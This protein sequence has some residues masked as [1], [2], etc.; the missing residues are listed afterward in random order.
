[1]PNR[2]LKMLLQLPSVFLLASASFSVAFPVYE[3]ESYKNHKETKYIFS[4]G[5]SYTTTGYNYTLALPSTSNTIGNPAFPGATLAGGINWIGHLTQTYN[6]SLTLTYNYAVS[7]AT[8]DSAIVA[9]FVSSATPMTDQVSQFLSPI[10]P[11]TK[12]ATA[13]WTAENSLFSVFFGINDIQWSY[14]GTGPRPDVYEK[15]AKAMEGQVGKLW[16]VGA[17]RFLIMGVPPFD[18]TPYHLN[19]STATIRTDISS[20][21]SIYNSLITSTLTSF[22]ALHP[23]SSFTFVNMTGVFLEALNN[24]EKYGAGKDGATCLNVD[25]KSC[26]WWDFFHPGLA[27]QKLMAE[28][29][30]K[31]LKARFF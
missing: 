2:C 29:V 1:M 21:I 22:Q 7:G 25:G 24:P 14:N 17:R 23:A 20:A 12:P 30:V 13:P 16:N 31:A 26:L 4:F 11:S 19:N 27:I 15:V 5:D 28:E 10:G 6:T 9:P 8:V 3:E 18:R